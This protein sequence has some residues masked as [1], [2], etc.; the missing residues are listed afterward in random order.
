MKSRNTPNFKLVFLFG[1]PLYFVGWLRYK[2]TLRVRVDLGIS[3]VYGDFAVRSF[4]P[5]NLDRKQEEF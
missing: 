5:F 1:S 3:R 2:E 4:L